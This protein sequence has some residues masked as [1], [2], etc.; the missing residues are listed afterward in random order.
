MTGI[1]TQVL[2]PTF[3]SFLLFLSCWII[4]QFSVITNFKHKFTRHFSIQFSPIATSSII[5]SNTPRTITT[6][7][8]FSVRTMVRSVVV[9]LRKRFGKDKSSSRHREEAVESPQ[10]FHSAVAYPEIP[11]FRLGKEF[12]DKELERIRTILLSHHK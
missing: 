3:A 2:L 1:S 8:C 6:M 12:D 11:T 5:N 7:A 10:G 9:R 4:A